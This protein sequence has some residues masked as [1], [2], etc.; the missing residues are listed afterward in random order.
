MFVNVYWRLVKHSLVSDSIC[1]HHQALAPNR[2]VLLV[3]DLYTMFQ[4]LT[5]AAMVP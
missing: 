1:M 4:G 3:E 2:K 5:S